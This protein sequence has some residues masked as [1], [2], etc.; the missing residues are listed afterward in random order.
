[1]SKLRSLLLGGV[2]VL[3]VCGTAVSSDFQ[4]DH[5][6][7]EGPFKSPMEVTAACLECHED[8][9]M[10][11]MATSHWSW[12][13]EQ[14]VPG[15]GKILRGKKNSINNL[16]ISIGGNWPRCTS[17]HI[18]YGWK[19]GTFDFSDP[20]RVD[21]LACHDTTGKYFKAKDA[22]AGSGMVPG[23]T[24]NKKFDANP[25]DLVTMAQNAGKPS[26][27][28]CLNCHANGG[29]GNNA[30]HGDIDRSLYTPNAAI[31]IHMAVDGNDFSCQDCHVTKEHQ[32]AGNASVV[33]PYG[34][35]PVSCEECHEDE[36][37]KNTKI[38]GVYNKH[39]KRVACQSCH[40]PFFA[41]KYATKTEW[42][43]SQAKSPK[44][45]PENGKIIKKGGNDIY[46]YKMGS[47]VYRQNVKPV[48]KWYDGTAGFYSMGDE[49]DPTKVT[50]LNY[51]NGS[52]DEE[53]SKIAPFKVLK[54]VQP[55][56][57]KNNIIITPKFFGK[58]DDPD[59]FW[60][61]F[62]WKKAAAA[63]MKANGLEFSG[64][65]GFTETVTYWPTNHMVSPAHKALKCVHCHGKKGRMNW[66][67]LGYKDDPKLLAKLRRLKSQN[68]E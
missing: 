7:I 11:V 16:C 6:S 59:A 37:H 13:S 56:D 26:R 54:G 17:C 49:M 36:P 18:G 34:N 51:P 1:M 10:E 19:D 46:I 32:I 21:C 31:D 38:N 41:K 53:S 42:D 22:P 35:N 62:D 9:S 29:G 43:W 12:S 65:V 68:K 33:S 3:M 55:Y 67:E 64:E 40:I 14:E 60:V 44:E 30:K 5:E 45:L 48:Y 8:A 25:Y 2:A 4:E 27:A 66:Q 61:N 63:G 52:R 50:Q 23:H 15:K 28:N 47:F 39:T 20:A 58:K 24:G 57:K